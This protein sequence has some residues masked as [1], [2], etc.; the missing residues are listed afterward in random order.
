VK[1]KE[2]LLWEHQKK[3]VALAIKRDEFA[4][5]FDCGCLCGDA[6]VRINRAGCS[7]EYAIADLYTRFNGFM[8]GWDEDIPTMIRSFKDTE[9]YIGLHEITS[10]VQ[11]GKKH[12]FELG[13]RNGFSL[14]LT[15]DHE[16][17]TKRGFVAVAKLYVL[18]E[19]MVDG[20]IR[21][22]TCPK[23]NIPKKRSDPR[24]CVGKYHPY[25]RKQKI[26]DKYCFIIERH[27][28]IFEANINGLSL[29][30]YVIATSLENSLMFV[31]P[32]KIPYTSR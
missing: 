9:G 29:E 20:L 28:A 14:R 24:I 13:L 15:D 2:P 27:R 10:V 4:F 22:Q 30:A 7:R 17:M 3:A 31:D 8:R 16:V 1:F 32:K 6:K 23:N 19:V 21:Y 5:F 25:A 12:V 26:H 11:S 18:D